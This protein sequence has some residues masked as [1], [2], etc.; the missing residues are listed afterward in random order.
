MEILGGMASLEEVELSACKGI[1][2]A[3]L[4]HLAKL[5]RLRKVSFDA[6]ARVSRAALALFPH[7]VR[8]DFWT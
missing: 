5:P 6:T 1:S 4:A 8:V 7:D 3:G 2:N